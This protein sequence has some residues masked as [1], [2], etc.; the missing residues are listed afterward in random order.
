MTI[1]SPTSVLEA[2][3]TLCGIDCEVRLA[4]ATLLLLVATIRV[5]FIAVGHDDVVTIFVLYLLRSLLD[6][7]PSQELD[8]GGNRPRPCAVVCY[9]SILFSSRHVGV[10]DFST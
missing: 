2:L 8:A 6:G 4:E 1:T 9:Y 3:G 5:K 10:M 7:I